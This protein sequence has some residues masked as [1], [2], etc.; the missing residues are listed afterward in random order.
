MESFWEPF[1]LTV[2]LSLLTSLLL[3]P[4]SVPIAYFVVFKKGLVSR[5]LEVVCNLPMVLPPTVLGF[6]LLLLMGKRG[7]F[8][9]LWEKLFGHQLAFH[10]EGLVVASI[11]FSLPMMVNSLTSGFRSVPRVL[12]EASLTLGKTPLQ[13]LWYVILPNSKPAILAGLILSFV[14]TMGEFGVVLMV[15]GNIPG[16]TRTLSI[17][18]YDATES[19]DYRTAHLYSAILIAV[20][21]VSLL[22]LLFMLNRRDHDK[23]LP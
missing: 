3:L 17:A 1:Y 18:I 8:G 5:I 13:T 7:P 2:K 16:Q 12:I 6:Y 21:F 10:F 20:S 9:E 14:H 22:A 11:I 4:I 23:G 15:G 19:L